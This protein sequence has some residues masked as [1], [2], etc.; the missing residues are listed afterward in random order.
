M[1]TLSRFSRS[2]S[3]SSAAKS[4]SSASSSASRSSATRATT[5]AA[6]RARRSS[7]NIAGRASADLSTAANLNEVVKRNQEQFLRTIKETGN[8]ELKRAI[9]IFEQSTRKSAVD[10]DRAL[11]QAKTEFIARAEQQ[12]NKGKS[13]F[14]DLGKAA[15]DI[16]SKLLGAAG[17]ALD[18][19]SQIVALATT[20]FL[21]KFDELFLF[22]ADKIAK[23]IRAQQE[24]VRQIT[25]EKLKVS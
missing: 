1:S 9:E 3:S 7:S 11:Q 25:A 6:A 20:T 14:D 19:L 18:P 22:D 12:N 2:I 4:F 23:A 8:E 17:D 21:E 24:A 10:L 13:I 15:K 16:L 5:I